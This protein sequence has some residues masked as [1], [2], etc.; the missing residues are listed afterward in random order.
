[1]LQYAKIISFTASPFRYVSWFL[2]TLCFVTAIALWQ[3]TH[4]WTDVAALS[5]LGILQLV[6]ACM[7]NHPQWTIKAPNPA[8]DDLYMIGDQYVSASSLEEAQLWADLSQNENEPVY[9]G[10]VNYFEK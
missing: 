2:S 4:V 6:E 5:V 3:K 9:I 7:M 1:M 10:R 8:M